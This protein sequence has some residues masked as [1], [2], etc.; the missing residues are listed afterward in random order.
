M[1]GKVRYKGEHEMA[2]YVWVGCSILPIN[3]WEKPHASLCVAGD[4][5]KLR[6]QLETINNIWKIEKIKEKYQRLNDK[7]II[8]IWVI[9]KQKFS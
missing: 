2:V 9:I 6:E 4:I 5:I 7:R 1:F 8:N 3:V